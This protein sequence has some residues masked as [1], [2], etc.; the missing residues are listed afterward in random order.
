LSTSRLV[1]VL[2]GVPGVGKTTLAKM[3][4]A[5]LQGKHVDLSDLARSEGFVTGWDDERETGLAD[6]DGIRRRVSEILASEKTLVI[7]GHFA[8]DI[9]PPEAASIVFVLRRA[10]WKLKKQLLARGYCRGKVKEN[11]EAE[12]LDVCLVD[13]IEAY[14]P[15]QVCEVDTTD[16]KPE[17]V[18]EEILSIIKGDKPCSRGRMDW[19]G[20][21][22]AQQLLEDW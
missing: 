12:L 9:V 16:R 10:P 22:E 7:E 4:V 5:R 8:S 3:L 21:V 13:A 18:V 17:D 6:L 2:T 15:E 14:E 19:L 1:V 11:V 20:R